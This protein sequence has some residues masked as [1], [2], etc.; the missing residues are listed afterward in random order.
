MKCLAHKKSEKRAEKRP[1]NPKPIEVK[2]GNIRLRIY[3]GATVNSGVQYPLFTLAY[4]EGGTRQRRAFGSLDKAKAEAAKIAERLDQGDHDALKFKSADAQ[5]FALASRELKPLDVPLLDAVRQYVAAMK[6]LPEGSSL[7]AAAKDYAQRH[8]TIA[9]SKPLPE[10]VDEFFASKAQDGASPVYLRT[11][12]Y[13]LNPLRERFNTPI[14]NIT[15]GDLDGWLRSLGHSPRTRKNAAVTITTL[16]R[17][18]R[19]LGYLPKNV[20]TEAENV[21]RPKNIK[22]GKIEMLTPNEL[23][24]ILHAADTDERRIYFALGAFTGIRAAEL[25]RLDWRDINRARG[26]VEITADNAKTASRRLVPICPALD[27][28]LEPFADKH[29][30][31]FSSTREA[32]RL[33][34]WAGKRIGRWPKNCLRHSFVSYRVAQSQDIAKTALEAGNSPAIIFSNYRELITPAEAA[35]WFGIMPP[36]ASNNV[37]KKKEIAA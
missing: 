25:Q 14:A 24:T 37:A 35:Q 12:R 18:A 10:V 30:K 34:E 19:G 31:V 22:G 36:E 17:F 11:M 28:W 7:L 8:P 33:V 9:K 5:S 13:H 16:F 27:S 21:T 26:H 4:Y 3:Q 1:Q 15:A 2:R 29:G 6:S 23:Q 20:P 32:E